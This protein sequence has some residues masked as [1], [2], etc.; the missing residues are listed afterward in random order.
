VVLTGELPTSRLTGTTRWLQQLPAAKGHLP[1][2]TGAENSQAF[3][4]CL[5]SIHIQERL[6]KNCLPRFAGGN[7]CKPLLAADKWLINH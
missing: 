4:T 2:F 6:K 1:G 7:I 5:S 3:F